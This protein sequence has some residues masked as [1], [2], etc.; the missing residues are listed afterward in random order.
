[1]TIS[2]VPNIAVH[3]TIIN[4]WE[5]NT[6]FGLGMDAYKAGHWSNFVPQFFQT[7]SGKPI[8]MYMF[9]RIYEWCELSA[10]VHEIPD[11]HAF[12]SLGIE[13]FKLIHIIT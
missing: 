7:S 10:P 1:M 3:W 8:I 6:I 11:R 5:L 9:R 4:E 12:P 13:F 2:I